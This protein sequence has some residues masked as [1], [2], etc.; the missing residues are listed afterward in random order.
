M[1]RWAKALAV[2]AAGLKILGVQGPIGGCQGFC[3]G[4]PSGGSVGPPRSARRPGIKTRPLI[5]FPPWTNGVPLRKPVRSQNRQRFDGPGAPGTARPRS[6]SHETSNE[7]RPSDRKKHCMTFLSAACEHDERELSR[8]SAE[9][10]GQADIEDAL[11]GSA[12]ARSGSRLRRVSQSRARRRVDESSFDSN[13]SA[14]PDVFSISWGLEL[15][16]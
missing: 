15:T 3:V 1:V 8:P 6:S 4:G 7:N 12:R 9:N 16:E 5:R 13:G 14:A 2:F 11:E 10:P